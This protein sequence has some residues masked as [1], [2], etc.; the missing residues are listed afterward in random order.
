MLALPVKNNEKTLKQTTKI[1][2]FKPLSKM[3]A[4]ESEL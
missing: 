1:T 4:V 2:L 3:K